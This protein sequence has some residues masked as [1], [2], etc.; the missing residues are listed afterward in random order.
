M[1]TTTQEN[2]ETS[3][4]KI[5]NSKSNS[6]I[7]DQQPIE[8]TPFLAVKYGDQYFL[9]LGKYRLTEPLP[10]LE[11]CIEETKD[12]SWMRLLQI[13]RVVAEEFYKEKNENKN[14]NSNSNI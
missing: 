8:G 7:I 2:T 4:K 1:E 5:I 11:A 12:T 10:S 9:A 6:K 3:A 13:M 14:N